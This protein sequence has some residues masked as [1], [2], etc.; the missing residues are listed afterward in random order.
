MTQSSPSRQHWLPAVHLAHFSTDTERQ[1]PRERRLHVRER[2]Q[3]TSHTRAARALGWEF[4]LYDMSTEVGFE[5]P[6]DSLDQT[7]NAYERRLSAAYKQVA[8]STGS[9]SFELWMKVLIPFVAGIT[10]RHPTYLGYLPDSM[11]VA[12]QL[13]R[14][15]EMTRVLAPLMAAD[16]S[17]LTAPSDSAFIVSDLGYVPV[18]DAKVNRWGLL[19]PITATAALLISASPERYIAMEGD[20]GWVTPL[21]RREMSTAE[22]DSTNKDMA[23]LAQR[24]VAGGSSTQID[25]IDLSPTAPPAGPAFIGWPD[26]GPLFT[27]D[28]AYMVALRMADLS[29]TGEDWVPPMC[30][31]SSEVPGVRRGV[32]EGRGV[33]AVSLVLPPD[34]PLWSAEQTP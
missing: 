6:A 34:R 1:K 24:W 2:G 9:V 21:P 19:V 11:N 23:R 29:I 15:T 7:F 28:D 8:E 5:V 31:I 26:I 20:S 16:W 30:M 27:H 14:M 12:I 17:L 10:V 33:I 32:F 25:A 13:S 3:P 18:F 22:V 4:D